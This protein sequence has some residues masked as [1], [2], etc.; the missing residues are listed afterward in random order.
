MIDLVI[1]KDNFKELGE[2]IVFFR[3]YVNNP[4]KNMHFA[5]MNVYPQIM[6]IF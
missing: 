5:F 2:F 1:S 6:T 3:K 4:Y